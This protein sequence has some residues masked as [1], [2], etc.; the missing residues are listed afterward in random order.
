M[1]LLARTHWAN[2]ENNLIF[3]IIVIDLTLDYI[4]TFYISNIN[5]NRSSNF[6]IILYKRFLGTPLGIFRGV[7]KK[8]AKAKTK[9]LAFFLISLF[10]V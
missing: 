1:K 6:D 2:L 4:I 9:R 5:K 7:P 3:E 8:S 10:I